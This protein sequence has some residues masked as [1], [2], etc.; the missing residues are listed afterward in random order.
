MGRRERD[1]RDGENK[2]TVTSPMGKKKE[3]KIVLG[4]VEYLNLVD[5]H[6]RKS[7]GNKTRQHGPAASQQRNWI[8]RWLDRLKRH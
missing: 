8:A 6:K 1:G 2:S 4:I 5:T 7:F 3:T